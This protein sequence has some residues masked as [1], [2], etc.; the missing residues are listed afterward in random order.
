LLRIWLYGW[1]ERVRSCRALE[2]ACER[3]I[4]FLW[5]SD[6]EHPDHNTIWRF[7]R[8]NK[9]ALG[10]LFKLVVQVAAKAGAVGL[11]LHA[12]DGT[13]VRAACSNKTILNEARLNERLAVVDKQINE[14][15]TMID[16]AQQNGELG[17]EL[18]QALQNRQVCKQKIQESLAQLHEADR[19]EMHPREPDARRMKM[20]ECNTALGYNPQ[21]VVDQKSDLIVAQ[22]VVSDQNDQ[23]QLVPMLDQVHDNLGTVADASVGDAGYDCGEELQKAENKG[24]RVIVNIGKADKTQGE[25][26]KSHFEYDP[27]KDVYRC[28]AGQVIPLSRICP[29]DK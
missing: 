6:L 5:L 19:K 9:G 27:E 1:F 21:I 18:P 16:T 24:Y 14:F 25:F 29:P 20:K 10:K 23:A 28:P 7:F 8:D 4:A 11:A 15:V 12:I 17:A 13:K 22:D 26:S 3:D 2:K